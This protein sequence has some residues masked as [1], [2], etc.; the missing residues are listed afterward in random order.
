MQRSFRDSSQGRSL[1]PDDGAWDDGK[2]R[3]IVGV[4]P[5]KK[6]FLDHVEHSYIYFIDPD[7]EI[8]DEYH[9]FPWARGQGSL[10]LGSMSGVDTLRVSDEAR[11]GGQGGGAYVHSDLDTV[12]WEGNEGQAFLLRTRTAEAAALMNKE[13]MDYRFQ[14]QNCLSVMNTLLYAMGENILDEYKDNK[15]SLLSPGSS[16]ILLPKGWR[17]TLDQFFDFADLSFSDWKSFNTEVPNGDFLKAFKDP[18]VADRLDAVFDHNPEL[19]EKFSEEIGRLGEAFETIEPYSVQNSVEN[20]RSKPRCG[21]L[22][23]P[24]CTDSSR[25]RPGAARPLDF[26]M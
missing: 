9:G 19:R 3:V 17:S 20:A 23:S 18:D 2:W 14:D 21:L 25:F 11:E 15:P 13:N 1:V 16:R 12:V 24:S 10:N 8:V 4:D 5:G 22:D 6:L 26:S 7:G